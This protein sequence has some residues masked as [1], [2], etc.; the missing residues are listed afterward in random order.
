MINTS[1]SHRAPPIGRGQNRRRLLRPPTPNGSP[2]IESRKRRQG[3]VIYD[4]NFS[5]E[6]ERATRGQAP[7]EN[8]RPG[9]A[10][11]RETNVAITPT[12][13]ALAAESTTHPYQNMG[14]PRPG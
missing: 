7:T 3:C 12:T 13:S 10:H 6:R 2:P 11:G 1:W 9:K 4:E 14:G 5:A 8:G